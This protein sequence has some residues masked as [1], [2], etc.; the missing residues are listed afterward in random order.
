M[1]SNYIFIPLDEIHGYKILNNKKDKILIFNTNSI[2]T[3]WDQWPCTY[4][5]FVPQ[6]SVKRFF[7]NSQG[8]W[9]DFL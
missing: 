9:E 2:W 1:N 8:H 4:A 5:W 6:S 7:H 3:L